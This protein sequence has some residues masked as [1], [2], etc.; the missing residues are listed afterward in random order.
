MYL[1]R[2]L[3]MLLE[4]LGVPHE[5]FKMYQ[6]MAV[7]DAQESTESLERAAHFL[8]GHGLGSSFRLPS[9]LLN[10]SKLQVPLPEDR[11]FDRMMEYAVNHVLRLLK[12]KGE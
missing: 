5:T 10:L 1:N 8:E 3:I 11:F 6:D 2:P 4:G 9:V 12:H 7:Q